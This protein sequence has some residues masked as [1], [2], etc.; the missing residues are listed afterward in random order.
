MI[1]DD[2]KIK[3]RIKILSKRKLTDLNKNKNNDIYFYLYSKK[4][5]E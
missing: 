2:F 1:C 3:S 4:C 5:V